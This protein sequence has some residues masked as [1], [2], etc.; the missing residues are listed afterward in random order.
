M[1]D[2]LRRCCVRHL[3]GQ[4]LCDRLPCA[5]GV[6]IATTASIPVH[7]RLLLSSDSHSWSFPAALPITQVCALLL[8]LL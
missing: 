8:R 6:V 5:A 1:G 2:Y 4:Q 3:G 7:D